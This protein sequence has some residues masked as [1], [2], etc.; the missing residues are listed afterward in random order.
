MLR[1]FQVRPVHWAGED[2]HL[3]PA[4][5][6]VDVAVEVWSVA[7]WLHLTDANLNDLI[8]EVQCLCVMACEWWHATG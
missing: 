5:S 4:V 8:D 2:P 1:K 6:V 7:D 3:F